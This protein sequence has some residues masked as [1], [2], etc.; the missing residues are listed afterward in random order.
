MKSATVI[1]AMSVLL[2]G[3]AETLA[4][5]DAEAAAQRESDARLQEQV[6]Q[7]IPICDS[8]T[9]CTRIWEAAQ[10]WVQKNA[11]L[12]L[13]TVTSV[14]IETYN[15]SDAVPGLGFTITKE[16][17]GGGRYRIIAAARCGG[18][19]GCEMRP[20]SAILKFNQEVGAAPK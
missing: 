15:P 20:I 17:L 11:S 5:H 3:C 19:F 6:D 2:S 4:R 18:M 7:S 13:Q 1:L 8:E 16:P 12:K 14:I 9:S 10:L